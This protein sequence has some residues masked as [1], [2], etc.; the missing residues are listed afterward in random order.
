MD[1][2]TQT[3]VTRR[4]VRALARTGEWVAFVG[5]TL[6]AAAALYFDGPSAW[7]VSLATAYL[8]G[9][10]GARTFI[11]GPWLR[12]GVAPFGFV[13]VLC[14][15]LSLAPSNHRDW[16]P[17]VA[18]APHAAIAGNFVTIYGIRNCDYRTERDYTVRYYDKA[19]DLEKLRSVDLYLVYWGFPNIAHTMVSFGFDGGD[20]VCISIETRKEKG[21]SYSALKGFFRQY[22]LVYVIADER[23]LVRLRTNYRKGEE[24][25]LYRLNMSL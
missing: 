19:F 22:E 1:P 14:W 16:E 6:W 2:N 3:N 23:D 21:E 25:Y 5:M 20:Y 8:L 12:H 11:K 9:M 10:L 4:E 13:I 18:I 15:W 7:R 17:D 24:V